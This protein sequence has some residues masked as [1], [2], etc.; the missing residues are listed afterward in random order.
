MDEGKVGREE[1]LEM[2][3]D[4]PKHDAKLRRSTVRKLDFVLLPF[5]AVLFL[6]NALDKCNVSGDSLRLANMVV[7]SFRLRHPNQLSHHCSVVLSVLHRHSPVL[8]PQVL[9]QKCHL[10]CL[11]IRRVIGKQMMHSH[12]FIPYSPPSRSA[13]QNPPTSLAISAWPLPT[14]T[15]P[16][17]S[18]SLSSLLCNPLAQPWVADMAWWSGYLVVWYCGDVRHWRMC[19]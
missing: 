7:A 6:C 13:T 3:G 15:P 9:S 18:S 5:L 2:P 8:L 1:E 11:R 10:R 4:D 17:P 14:L 12:H 19:G 16:S